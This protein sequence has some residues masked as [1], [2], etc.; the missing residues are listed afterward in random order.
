MTATNTDLVTEETYRRLAREQPD[1]QWELH[2]GRMR[3]KPAMSAE[4]NDLMFQLGFRLQ[5]RLDPTAFRVRV[6]AGRL[7]RPAG[8]SYIPDVAVLPAELERA[9][10]RG[11][12]HLETYDAPLPLV[13]EVW[14]PSTGDYDVTEKLAEYQARG[15][16]EI[17]LLHPYERTLTAWV[18]QPG[19]AYQQTTHR[20]G[21]VQPAFLPDVAIDL[22][23]LFASIV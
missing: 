21:V 1:R 22:D 14:S 19:G 11:A 9:E 5:L 23:A 4:H 3:E 10:R 16:R 2:R 7:R 18:R 13:V 8:T 6:N 12:G 20:G 17:W 15:D